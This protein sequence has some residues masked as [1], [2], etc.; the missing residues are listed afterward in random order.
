MLIT[1]RD[2]RKERGEQ[3]Q[4]EATAAGKVDR[5]GKEAGCM[6]MSTVPQQ[7]SPAFLCAGSAGS[8]GAERR[9]RGA[10]SGPIVGWLGR[11]RGG[12]EDT[13]RTGMLWPS[14]SN[15]W[16]RTDEEERKQKQTQ[17]AEIQWGIKTKY[18]GRQGTAEI[19]TGYARAPR[20]VSTGQERT[21]A[22]GQNTE[23]R[24]GK[25]GKERLGPY[26][27]GSTHTFLLHFRPYQA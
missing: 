10:A 16:P 12:A 8:A 25:R 13:V 22:Q 15:R 24:E 23:R 4:N 19:E 3:L 14:A 1:S 21:R 5:G 7:A 9:R 18:K 20:T 17:K 26:K 6:M 27:R 11:I 2:V